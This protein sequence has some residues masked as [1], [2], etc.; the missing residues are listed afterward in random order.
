MRKFIVIAIPVATLILFIFVM[1][2]DVIY[3]MYFDNNNIT[4]SINLIIQDI[5]DEKW[6]DADAEIK[7]LSESWK[8]VVRIIQFSAELDE[9]KLFDKNMSRLKGAVMAKD[10]INALIELNEALEHWE[11]IDE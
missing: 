9:I 3:K 6:I 1:Q 8:K 2:S 4:D 11:N 5:K 7:Q 10:K